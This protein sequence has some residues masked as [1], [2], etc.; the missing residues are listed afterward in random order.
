MAGAYRRGVAVPVRSR[1]DR[2]AHG[3][4]EV[5]AVD[6][7]TEASQGVDRDGRGMAVVVVGAHPDQR[8]LGIDRG[9]EARIRRGCAVVRHREQVRLEAGSGRVGGRAG[10]QVGLRRPLRIAGE[11]RP[12][13]RPGGPHDQGTVVRLAVGVPVRPPRVG[14]QHGQFDVADHRP[15]TGHRRAD[16]DLPVGGEREHLRH[17]GH[18]RLQR[19]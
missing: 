17:A 18:L 5:G 4:V 10:Q 7:Y 16:R 3:A 11:Q 1:G 15:V 19:A 6:A 2:D 13:P 9:E 8:H 12:P 14:P